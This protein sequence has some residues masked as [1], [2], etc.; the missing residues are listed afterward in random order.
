MKIAIHCSGVG[1]KPAK[2]QI[3]GVQVAVDDWLRAFFRY[4]GQDL[5]HFLVGDE[6]ARDHVKGL[7]AECD[8]D[9]DRLRMIDARF[10]AQNLA[11]F[12]VVFRVDSDPHDFF[13]ERECLGQGG[14][15]FCGLVHAIGGREGGNLLRRYMLE[16]T[17]KGDALVCPSEAVRGV[18]RSFWESYGTYLS[19]RFGMAAPACP[20]TLAR[21]PL[22]VDTARIQTHH[23]AAYRATLGLDDDTIVVLWVGRLSYA[24]KAHPLPMFQAVSQAA[25]ATGKKVAFVL[26]GYFVPED[27]AG[28]FLAAA[29]A[30]GPGVQTIFVANDDPHFPDGLWGV[31]DIFLSLV[32][33]PQESFGLTPIEA[34]A[35]G[36]PRV[37]SDWDGYR[38]SVTQGQDGFLIRT[39][40]P[41][42]GMGQALSAQ[43][44]DGRE[45]YGGVMAKIAQCVAVDIPM[46]TQ[47][48][49][50]L[51][52][53]PDLR[54]R[55]ADAARQRL[56]AYDWQNVMKGYLALWESLLAARDTQ[57]MA[58]LTG[59]MPPEVPD[60]FDMFASYATQPFALSDRVQ[61]LQ[62]G[63]AIKELWRHPMN[64][65]AV[66]ILLPAQEIMAL[67]NRI[68]AAKLMTIEEI[69][70][71]SP[72]DVPRFWRTMGWLAKLGVIGVI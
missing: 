7:A 48:L 16:P 33:N 21:V 17:R 53:S 14:P 5:F 59:A 43:V 2:G 44:L 22:G 71:Q 67:I 60:P 57:A 27:T 64:V 36:L 8:I 37:L 20:L 40:Q 32:D 66:D 47:A 4:A 55:L 34:I 24:I 58:C 31:G 6:A 51:M 63:A 25:A 12:D 62:S 61:I 13:W 50:A 18:V 3:F 11:A 52:L 15:V 72:C 35:A 29:E 42:A 30:F 41:P 68:A 45:T 70:A 19:Q 69:L 54:A 10:G 9:P 23:R 26:Q 39:R 65:M 49:T 1:S 46:A 38:D 56:A 28:D